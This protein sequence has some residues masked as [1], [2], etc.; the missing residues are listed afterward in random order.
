VKPASWPRYM[1]EKRTRRGVAYYWRPPGRDVVKGCPVH[2]EALG[3][4]FGGAIARAQLLNVHLDSWRTGLS[5]PK[6]INLGARFGT[7]DWWIESYLRSDAYTGLSPR[8]REDY[9]EALARVADIKTNLTDART[10][11]RGRVGALPVA[12][13]TPAA[14]D[15]LYAELRSGGAVRQANYPIDVARRAWKVIARK[16]PA[17]F[18]IPNP[19]N[20]KE[21]IALNPF[22]GVERARSEGTTEPASR[23]DAYAL[24]EALARIGHPALGAAALICYE[25]LQR[26]EN[27]L[28]GKISWT[29]YR[30]SH[31]PA[32]VRIDH[33]KTK[34]KIWQPLEDEEGQLYPE[35]EAFLACV[36]RLGIPIVLLEP[37][38]GAKNAETGKR[39]PRL[40]SFEHARH[41]VQQARAN[42]NLPKHVTLAACRHGGMTELG[43]AGLTEPQIMSLSGHQT[44]AAARVYVKRTEIQRM[45]AVRKRRQF[46]ERGR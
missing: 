33:H 3:V 7:V 40:Y 24:A 36:P 22:V 46:V 15:K 17:Q 27:V 19:L 9:R 39:T 43:D 11:E 20:A 32:A 2:S 18:L 21:R 37:E 13:L 14:V 42:V 44:P 8:S 30:P 45:S 28:A 6:D 41:L 31:H 5:N 26:P 23:A 29:D 25:W 35:L 4:D 38:R 12:S 10:G 1:V 34:K 16:H